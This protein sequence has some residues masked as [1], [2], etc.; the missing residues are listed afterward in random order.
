MWRAARLAGVRA[1]PR[2]RTSLRR[3][4]DGRLLAID[5]TTKQRQWHGTH[6]AAHTLHELVL[7]FEPKPCAPRGVRA[8]AA[9]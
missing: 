2:F 6:K 1:T 4:A 9:P 8:R 5:K 7:H 3:S